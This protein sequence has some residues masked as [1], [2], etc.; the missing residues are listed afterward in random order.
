MR[1]LV[2]NL[3]QSLGVAYAFVAEFAGAEDRVKTIAFWS[4]DDWRAN[5]EYRLSG[6]PCSACRR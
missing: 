6:T 2:K 4:Q 5:V 1:H 3:A